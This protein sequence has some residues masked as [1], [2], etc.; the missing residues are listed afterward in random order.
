MN[1]V[2]KLL[3]HR[4]T[5]ASAMR[6]YYIMKLHDQE[7]RADTSYELAWMGLWA[8]AEISLGII[9]ACSFSLPK[10]WREK[11]V[12]MRRGLSR[13]NQSF[14]SIELNFST[15][16]SKPRSKTQKSQTQASTGLYKKG[17]PLAGP[18]SWPSHIDDA[19]NLLN[20]ESRPHF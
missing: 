13:I 15:F 9:C 6:I 1:S 10:V 18:S 7:D 2:A 5:F 4:A 12:G 11:S 19:G 16:I 14:V 20:S 17:N 8:W 3:K